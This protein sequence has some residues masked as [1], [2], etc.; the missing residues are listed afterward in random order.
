MD[1]KLR[2]DLNGQD[3]YDV[4]KRSLPRTVVESAFTG[5]RPHVTIRDY[6]K[7]KQKA[8]KDLEKEN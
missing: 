4:I 8:K 7:G 3:K 2:R 6:G 1:I 5:K